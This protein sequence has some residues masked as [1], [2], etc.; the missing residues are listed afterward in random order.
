MLPHSIFGFVG[1]N[2]ERQVRENPYRSLLVV[3]CPVRVVETGQQA[4]T[5]TVHRRNTVAERDIVETLAFDESC[6]DA[7]GNN[8]VQDHDVWQ[9]RLVR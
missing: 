5:H 4:E 7:L 9:T 2:A 6:L 8:V 3:H 1:R